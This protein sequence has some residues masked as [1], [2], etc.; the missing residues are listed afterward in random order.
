[1]SNASP[2]SCWPPA[3]RDDD[4]TLP[5]AFDYYQRVVYDAPRLAISLA[6]LIDRTGARRILD[7]AAGSGLPALQLRA[8]GYTIDC[9]DGDPDMVA[10]FQRN[11]R[12]LD[13]DG[14]CQVKDW[15]HLGPETSSSPGRYDY[16]LCRGNSL[17][18]A[19][20]WGGGDRVAD[21][22]CLSRYLQTFASLLEPGGYLH[23]DAPRTTTTTRCEASTLIVDPDRDR[24]LID[25]PASVPLEITVQEQVTTGQTSRCW[26]CSVSLQPADGPV[27]KRAFAMNSSKLTVTDLLD[28]LADI[29]LDVVEVVELDGDRECHETVLARKPT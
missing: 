5:E 6:A 28:L 10:R 9:S 15:S 26:E 16:L 14:S 18:Y 22:S 13:V 29:E 4:L 20:S 21:R 7:C 3:S 8:A 17:V 1:M 24:L 27:S 19:S 12:V 11:A 2:E 25:D 23:L